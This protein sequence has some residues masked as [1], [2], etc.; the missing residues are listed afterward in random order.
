M[1]ELV[2]SVNI[3]QYSNVIRE[4]ENLKRYYDA[5]VQA[6]SSKT[7]PQTQAVHFGSKSMVRAAVSDLDDI[8]TTTHPLGGFGPRWVPP[9]S[10][11]EDED[12]YPSSV[13]G[14]DNYL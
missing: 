11:H 8:S 7:T 14:K 1:D 4:M 12:D 2:A 10:V 9:S 6:G 13:L 5:K 3:S